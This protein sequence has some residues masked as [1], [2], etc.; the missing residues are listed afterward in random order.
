MIEIFGARAAAEIER[1]RAEALVRQT[2]ASLEQVVR[3]RTAQLEEANRDLESYN[4]SIS[5]D[6]RQPLNAI[7]GFSELLRDHPAG[8]ID[9]AADEY[10]REIETNSVRMEQMIDALLR[11]SQAGRGALSESQVDAQALFEGVLH[12]LSASAPL[13]AEVVVG[14]LP[15]ARGDPTLLRQ[16]W[17]NLLGNAIKYCGGSAAPRVEISGSRRDGMVEYV[18][19]DNGVGFDMRHAGRL[20]E[21]FQRLPTAGD[22]EGRGI[23]LAIVQRIVR[24]HGGTISAESAPGKGATFR[25]TLL[26]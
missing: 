24:R 26:G 17:A 10:L 21:A 15:P 9:A 8:T 3:E 22:F 19:R 16:V 23:G 11:L 12:D 18:V 7:A 2:N 25:F 13:A 1:A 6:L 14:E 5:H 20:F 4:Y